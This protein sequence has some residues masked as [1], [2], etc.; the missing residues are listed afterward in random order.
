MDFLSYSFVTYQLMA[1]GETAVGIV[2]NAIQ[3]E[4]GQA[5]SY[6]KRNFYGSDFLNFIKMMAGRFSLTDEE[7]DI[8]LSKK[9]ILMKMKRTPA[10]YDRYKNLGL[11][12]DIA[13]I[14]K[15]F[16]TINAAAYGQFIRSLMP[17]VKGMRGNI[18]EAETNKIFSLVTSQLKAGVTDLSTIE[19]SVINSI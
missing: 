8:I 3:M 7:I 19:A 10:G 15:Y 17:M 4:D 6:L 12:V 13:Y 5:I 16:G 18:T 2:R 1:K 9:S 14:Q 11:L